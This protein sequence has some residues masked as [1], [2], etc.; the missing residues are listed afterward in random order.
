MP[1]SKK[2]TWLVISLL[3]AVLML[4]GLT[5]ERWRTHLLAA[6]QPSVVQLRV[7]P[8][9]T[10]V[11]LKPMP[12]VLTIPSIPLSI[13]SLQWNRQAEAIKQYSYAI[14]FHTIMGTSDCSATAVGPNALLTAS[15]CEL[16][17]NLVKLS[18]GLVHVVK[19]ERDGFDH[20]ILLL[21]G[22][23][24]Q[25]YTTISEANLKVGDPIARVQ[26]KRREWAN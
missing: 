4:V 25:H 12:Q 20:S 2:L 23:T 9:P 14:A 22:Y 11:V 8:M 13:H 26:Q 24:F 10:H 15:H 21:N 18:T 6:V 16:P 17:T 5:L 3:A 7:M 19:T 1:R